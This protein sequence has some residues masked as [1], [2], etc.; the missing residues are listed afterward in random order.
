MIDCSVMDYCVV[1]VVSQHTIHF[2]LSILNFVSTAV[3]IEIFAVHKKVNGFH[4]Y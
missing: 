4:G 2:L 3:C 1:L